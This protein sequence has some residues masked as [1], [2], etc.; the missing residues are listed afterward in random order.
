VNRLQIIIAAIV[1]VP[2][3]FWLGSLYGARMERKEQEVLQLT[4][5]AKNDIETVSAIG[6]VI[7]EYQPIYVE[8]EK[9][10]EPPPCTAPPVLVDT[11]NRLPNPVTKD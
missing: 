8:V 5:N 9:Y 1:A 10:H 11:I 4:T 6:K 2:V 3:I 7:T